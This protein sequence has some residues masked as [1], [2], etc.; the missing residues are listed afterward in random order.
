[1]AVTVPV[2]NKASVCSVPGA[3]PVLTH[4]VPTMFYE[5]NMIYSPPLH[6]VGQKI[7][8]ERWCQ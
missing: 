7:G 6:L 3:G 4:I 1:M 5:I 8:R 2:A